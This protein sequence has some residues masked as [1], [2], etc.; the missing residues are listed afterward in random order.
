[1]QCWHW[2]TSSIYQF[3][4]WSTYFN[5]VQYYYHT[6]WSHPQMVMKLYVNLPG[7]C[8]T[9]VICVQHKKINDKTARDV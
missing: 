9:T 6:K 8:T 4:K 5:V 2:P 7:L 1:M 3:L